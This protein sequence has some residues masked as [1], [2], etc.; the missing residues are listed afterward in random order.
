MTTISGFIVALPLAVFAIAAAADDSSWLDRTE[1]RLT[2]IYRTGNT[3]FYLPLHTHHLRA[4]YSREKIDSFQENPIGIG[5]GRGLYDGDGDWYGIYAMG[6]QDSHFTPLWM[7]GYGYQTFW[8]PGEKW[9]LGLGYTAFLMAR[10]ETGHY[11]PFPGILPVASVGYR[12]L[13]VETSLIPGGKGYGNIF[14]FWG[15]YEFGE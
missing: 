8:H 10:S 11:T 14:F 6:F 15:K 3:E 12:K 2:D 4:A 13:S 7:T 5:I 9:K 1:N